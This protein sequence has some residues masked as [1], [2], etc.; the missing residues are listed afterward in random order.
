MSQRK[1]GGEITASTALSSVLIYY[2]FNLGSS[3]A[4]ADLTLQSL[5]SWMCSVVEILAELLLQG[6]VDLIS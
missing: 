4:R 3:H 5:L 2:S 6:A 1:E